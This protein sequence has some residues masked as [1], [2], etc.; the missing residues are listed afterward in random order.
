MMLSLGLKASVLRVAQ[1]V[2]GFM[3]GADTG[4]SVV[5]RSRDTTLLGHHFN[6]Q[7][8]LGTG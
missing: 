6:T 3:M 5:S 7:Q 8:L 1:T 4:L 2:L